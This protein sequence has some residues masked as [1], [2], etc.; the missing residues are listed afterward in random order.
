MATP[1]PL[2]VGDVFLRNARVVPE[3]V[4]ASL[5]DR[6]LT[7]GELDAAGNRLAGA[8]R[9]MGVG[10]GDRVVSFADTSL[11]VL[12]LF[13]A[14]AKLGAVTALINTNLSGRP[15]AHSLSVSGAD[16]LI[17]DAA[18]SE[19]FL[20][21]VEELEQRPKVWASGGPVPDA[22]DLDAVVAQQSPVALGAAPA[23]GGTGAAGPFEPMLA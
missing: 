2:L 9:E 19:S 6:V 12:P 22:E 21:C 8:L 10:H 20:G 18:L 5:G 23:Q 13:V 3:R 11:D 17:L 14:L 1:H 16:H 7:H 15:L 4:A